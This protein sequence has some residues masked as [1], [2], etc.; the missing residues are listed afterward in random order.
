MKA[1]LQRT[2]IYANAI[3]RFDIEDKITK[4]NWVIWAR[5]VA[6]TED[7]SVVSSE[8]NTVI[9]IGCIKK[10]LEI[11]DDD[12]RDKIRSDNNQKQKYLVEK[13]DSLAVKYAKRLD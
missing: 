13:I 1:T 9:P 10:I 8:V 3:S 12:L 2:K 5:Y 11:I 4:K 6:A 7:D